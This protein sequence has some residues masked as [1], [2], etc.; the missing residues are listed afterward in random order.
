[1]IRG[2]GYAD[3]TFN[4]EAET[5]GWRVL[6][7]DEKTNQILLISA[8]IVTTESTDNGYFYLRG[9][10]GYEWG[11]KEL[12]NICEIFG[13]GNGAS[14]ARSITAEDINKITGYQTETTPYGK[15]S[16]YEYGN[17]VKYT[18]NSSDISYQDTLNNKSGTYGDLN[19]I[20]KFY[21]EENNLW[22][23]L[24]QGK[25][26][27]LRSSVYYYFPNT[28]TTSSSG[29][30]VGISTEDVEYEMLFEKN[31]S[32]QTYWL[33][34]QYIVTDTENAIFA[35]RLVGGGRVN[36]SRLFGSD[37]ITNNGFSGIRPIVSLNTNVNVSG[38]AG[39]EEEPYEIK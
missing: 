36:G 28:L 26:Q 34:S 38:G 24:T 33:M 15:G 6:G 35:L 23:T 14:G 16:I 31:S 39:T 2:N 12:N 13:K 19:T 3:Q 1:M 21:D 30:T 22:K 32:K 29:E 37:G 25:S 9:Q 8:D 5:N 7:V 20:F 18:K 4:V 11:I 27:S 10:T 17:K